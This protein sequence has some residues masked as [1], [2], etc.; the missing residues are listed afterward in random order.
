[1]ECGV[2]SRYNAKASLLHLRIIAVRGGESW[3][4]QLV[5]ALVVR[6]RLKRT[7][8][9]RNRERVADILRVKFLKVNP[10][11]KEGDA[12]MEMSTRKSLGS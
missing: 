3:Q 8:K 7:F 4:E 10:I 11:C 6:V 2:K 1:M 5:Q 12:T 9:D